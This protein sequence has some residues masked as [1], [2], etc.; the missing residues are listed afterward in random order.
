MILTIVG[1]SDV[2]A[3][4]MSKTSSIKAPIVQ[5]CWLF[6][7]SHT[8]LEPAHPRTGRPE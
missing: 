8:L 2:V 5:V 3:L 6:R 4:A 1:N 7:R